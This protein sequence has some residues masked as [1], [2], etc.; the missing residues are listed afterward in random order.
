MKGGITS[1]VV[2][3]GVVVRLARRYRFRSIGGASVGAL[4]AAMTAAAEY[5][6]PSG[7]FQRLSQ[8][9]R[10]LASTVDGEPFILALFQPEPSTRR[11]FR[12]AVAFQRYGVARGAL[13]AI[14]RYWRFP[15][16][17]SVLFCASLLVIALDLGGLVGWVLAVVV[18]GVSPWVFLGGIVRDVVVDLRSVQRNDFG[19]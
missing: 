16:V 13:R 5:G 10:E 14:L 2:Y 11:L 3:P 18:L 1:G 8:V 4:A 9:P 19:L 7:G 17:A 12:T 15:F 6:R